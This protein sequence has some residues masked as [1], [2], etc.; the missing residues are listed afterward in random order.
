MDDCCCFGSGAHSVGTF[1]IARDLGYVYSVS[2]YRVTVALKAWG[3]ASLQLLLL[4]LGHF[5]VQ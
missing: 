1:K 3:Q 5:Y 2:M 4:F